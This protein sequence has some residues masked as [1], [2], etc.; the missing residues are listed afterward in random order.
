MLSVVICP[1]GVCAVWLE[2]TPR[3]TEGL[4]AGFEGQE[5]VFLSLKLQFEPG[6]AVFVQGSCIHSCVGQPDSLP[7][8]EGSCVRGGSGEGPGAGRCPPPARPW[9]YTACQPVL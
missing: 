9:I 7:H 8:G 2:R 1:F 4:G 3:R 5:S 6:K